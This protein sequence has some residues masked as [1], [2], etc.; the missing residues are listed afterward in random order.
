MPLV[1][2]GRL[3]KR[4]P[5]TPKAALKAVEAIMGRATHDRR[6]DLRLT[7]DAPEPFERCAAELPE[8]FAGYWLDI[9]VEP[10]PR[11]LDELVA[12][13]ETLG[14]GQLTVACTLAGRDAEVSLRL[15]GPEALRL[16][17]ERLDPHRQHLYRPR[18][19]VRY[20]ETGER[21]APSAE[22]RACA[23]ARTRAAAEVLGLDAQ[24]RRAVFVD[25]PRIPP[26]AGPW[27]EVEPA[28][29]SDGLGPVDTALPTPALDALKGTVV[30]DTPFG[31]QCEVP[32]RAER[33]A[34]W[35]RWSGLLDR[36]DLVLLRCM[37][38]RDVLAGLLDRFDLHH[39]HLRQPHQ[40][41]G[42]YTAHHP[43]PLPSDALAAIVGAPQVNHP[44]IE[45]GLRWSSLRLKIDG[46]LDQAEGP[47]SSFFVVRTE[48]GRVYDSLHLTL[49]TEDP[50]GRMLR[51]A[52]RQL[53][54]DFGALV[55]QPSAWQYVGPALDSPRGR[56]YAALRDDLAPLV[57]QIT[58]A[59][60]PIDGETPTPPG[61]LG[62]MI[63][64]A[65]S[66]GRDDVGPFDLVAA[67]ERALLEALPGFRHE[68]RAHLT[69]RYFIP[70]SRHT[71]HGVHLILLR[72]LHRPDGFRISVGVST[73]PLQLADLD[74]GTGR[75]APGLAIP[76]AELVPE[77]AGLDWRYAG[78]PSAEHAV[79][80]AIA[81]LAAR[82][83]PY[84]AVADAV[85]A[86]HG[87][88][89]LAAFDPA[90]EREPAPDPPEKTT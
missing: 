41:F 18:M 56:R 82:A 50:S 66:I 22:R 55:E 64:R 80:D 39:R 25:D 32:D 3:L 53:A 86:R 60:A 23:A 9:A 26:A 89:D 57:G 88:Q 73:V 68:R 70:F 24:Q 10:D 15:D 4:R 42:L 43:A 49:E 13:A 62:R 31:L 67:F 63:E 90:A 34:L 76:L 5:R 37:G 69:D 59:P 48:R 44:L 19:T 17:A 84:F 36:I 71:A 81:V 52:R 78:H 16:D 75:S 6:L 1:Y 79:A 58:A 8:D 51:N 28:H 87:Q 12:W 77:R 29:F 85:L 20:T 38:R 33:I 11:R 35:R 54:A 47:A 45:W 46:P 74:P 2:Q 21:T 61:W 40:T 14:G 27:L 7:W 30:D 72:R 65:R 83:A